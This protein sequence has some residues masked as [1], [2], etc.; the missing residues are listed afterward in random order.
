MKQVKKI[1]VVGGGSAGLMSALILNRHLDIQIDVVYSKNISVVGVGEGST[2]H[3]RDF[4]D[5]VGIDQYTV[6][7]ECDAT[8][9]SGTMFQGW[10]HKDYL[11]SV[12][13][14]FSHRQGLYHTIYGKQI[15]ENNSY[16]NYDYFWK[17]RINKW[18]LNR[19]EFWP[20]NQF[21]FNTFKLNDFLIKLAKDRGIGIIEDDINSVNLDEYGY[22]KQL[23]GNAATYE[24][25]FYIDATGFKRLLVNKLG[26]KWNSYSKYLKVKAAIVFPT[27]DE[28]NYNLWTIAKAMDYG[29][30]FRTPV[31][32]RYGNGYIYDSDYITA[33][34]AKEEVEKLTG[35]KIEIG[36]EFKFDPGCLDNVWIKNCCA[37]GL[38]SSFVEPLEASSIGTTIQQTFLL[39]HRISN[40]DDKTAQEYNN[41]F[42]NI[43]EN[44]R[45]FIV[46]HYITDKTNTDF[47]KDVKNI[48]IPDSLQDKLEK[49]QHHLP[50]SEDFTNDSNFIL[51]KPANFILVME[52]LNLFNR[53]SIKRE[54]Q[55][56]NSKTQL[57][58]D[59]LLLEII[60]QEK[61]IETISHKDMLQLIRNN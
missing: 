4:M 45:D 20:F 56:L 9:K 12:I 52:G 18:F 53:E 43:M 30:A 14:Q 31:W 58:T 33:D 15:S 57:S 6:I 23:Q 26:A 49:W 50:V 55:S 24:Y 17:N 11:H 13:D 16:M 27:E 1:L 51:F 46:L 10:G 39:M 59:N 22:I 36:K 5:F 2:E 8:Y 41:V 40:Y 34:Q 19:K 37:V 60:Q 38:S 35:R 21:H 47:W 54:Y 28:N 3:F 61:T 32:G 42:R 48:K 7:K 29:W 44:I 25:D